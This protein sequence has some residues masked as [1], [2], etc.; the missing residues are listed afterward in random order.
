MRQENELT[1]KHRP[2][3][4]HLGRPDFVLNLGQMRDSALLTKFRI[5]APTLDKETAV[6]E[7]ATREIDGRRQKDGVRAADIG[8][9]I[10]RGRGRSSQRGGRPAQ[11]SAPS[12]TARGQR[13]GPGVRGG[14]G[15]QSQ[16][17]ETEMR[18]NMER[19]DVNSSLN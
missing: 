15:R 1:T 5:P 10:L 6:L 4:R 18:E 7:G 8:T 16:L 2:A 12:G 19:G 17:R 9:S 11:R 3:V 14:R 13:R